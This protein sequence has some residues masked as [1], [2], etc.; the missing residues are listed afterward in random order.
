MSVRNSTKSL[1]GRA[2]LL[3][4][5][6][7]MIAGPLAAKRNLAPQNPATSQ[8]GTSQP[9]TAQPGTQI[10]GAPKPGIAF[11]GRQNSASAPGNLP[12][13]FLNGQGAQGGQQ[14]SPD[15][16]SSIWSVPSAPK[17]S[18]FP[19]FP[20]QLPGYGNY[21][22]PINPAT[23]ASPEG[24][25]G[26]NPFFLPMA[27]AEPEPPGWPTW[28]R[29]QAKKPLPFA[30]DLGLLIMQDGRIWHRDSESDPFTPLLSHNK[31]ASLPA[32]AEVETRGAASFEV[33]LHESA[34]VQA[35]GLTALRVVSLDEKLVHIEFSKLSWL[36]INVSNRINRFTLPNG[37]MIELVAAAAPVIK[38]GSL[39]GGLATPTNI[40]SAPSVEIRRLDE[41]GSYGGRAT[42]TNFGGSD[43]VW[44][45][46]F[47]QTIIAPG[48]RVILFL[49]PPKSPTSAGLQTGGT[50]VQRRE[51]SV[52]C[53]SDTA[54]E[55]RWCGAK[56]QMPRGTKVT[57][58]SLGGA[59]NEEPTAAPIVPS[60]PP[61]AGAAS[62][63]NAPVGG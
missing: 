53:I 27:S 59:F 36:Q 10:P 12:G 61:Q 34:R 24:T 38:L 57:F 43:I 21:P 51:E 56:I 55:V 50:R 22:L 15:E 2:V 54:T 62:A 45:H 37:S 39:F 32:G 33:L 5:I 14:G 41:P 30:I 46:A 7:P 31:F 11:P 28:I 42:L 6:A 19:M 35:R 58:E 60:A 17:F 40:P 47:G 20:A 29:T 18:G 3:V 23:G 26:N 16:F 1:L 9:G 44:T 52:T 48:H 13:Q 63:A 25:I 8:P 4:V 49:T